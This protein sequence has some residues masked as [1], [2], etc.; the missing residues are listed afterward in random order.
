MKE[1]GLSPWRLRFR[2]AFSG[3]ISGPEDSPRGVLSKPFT[4]RKNGMLQPALHSSRDQLPDPEHDESGAASVRSVGTKPIER[5]D[6]E[7]TTTRDQA[8]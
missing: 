5:F 6:D 3:W 8:Q 1:P 4:F 2:P 7:P